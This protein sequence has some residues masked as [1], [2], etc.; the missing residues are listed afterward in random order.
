MQKFEQLVQLKLN[1]A[2]IDALGL[3]NVQ[4]VKYT[5]NSQ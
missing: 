4:D 2:H 3:T 5:I 1:R